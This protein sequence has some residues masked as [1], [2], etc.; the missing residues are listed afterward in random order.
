MVIWPG[1]KPI[2]S[3]NSPLAEQIINEWRQW[4]APFQSKPQIVSQ[5]EGGL[6][7][8]SYLIEAGSERAVLRINNPQASQLGINRD[9]EI[10]IL[11]KIAST[12]VAPNYYFANSQYLLSEYIE[13]ET[14]DVDGISQPAIRQ[15]IFQAIKTIQ[16][17][18]LP[19]LKRFN[20]KKYCQIYC[21]QIS[22]EYLGQLAVQQILDLAQ[23]IDSA[24][25]QPVLCHHDLIP[26]NIIHNQQGISI[27]DW[28]YAGLGHPQFDYL[29]I[30]N[31]QQRSSLGIEPNPYLERLQVVL[32]ELWF[33]VRYPVKQ[34]NLEIQLN[35]ILLKG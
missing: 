7:N 18:K 27:I 2:S 17:T 8:S 35:K 21:S 22:G 23:Q 4:Q 13:G 1:E 34:L 12:A 29:R 6:T 20:Y 15:Q 11:K 25:W 5:L 10:T 24:D 9:T 33:A 30:F 31:K 32:D 19:S 14:T 26:E 16:T 28:E 3:S